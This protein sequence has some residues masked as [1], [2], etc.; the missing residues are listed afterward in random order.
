MR[1]DDV[2]LRQRRVLSHTNAVRSRIYTLKRRI[3]K[4][5]H[6]IEFTHIFARRHV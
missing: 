2:A 1:F 5:K 6:V 3:Y 4:Y